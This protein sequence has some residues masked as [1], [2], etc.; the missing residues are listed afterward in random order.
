MLCSELLTSL[1]S[2]IY[3]WNLCGS[4]LVLSFAILQYLWDGFGVRFEMF[5]GSG[6]GWCGIRPDMVGGLVY[7]GGAV[8]WGTG[9]VK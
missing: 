3:A 5:C 6:A 2:S 7:G 8:R 9:G 1:M 4:N